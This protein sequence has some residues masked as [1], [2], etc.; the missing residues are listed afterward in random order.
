MTWHR[1]EFPAVD[2]RGKNFDTAYALDLGSM[3][4]GQVWMNGYHLGR[5][6]N[7]TGKLPDN[8]GS[9][10]PHPPATPSHPTTGTDVAFSID[11]EAGHGLRHGCDYAG[12]FF[13]DKC[14]NG[15]QPGEMTQRYYHVP[16]EWLRF[17]ESGGSNVVVLFEELGGLV[18]DVK[19]VRVQREASL[20]HSPLLVQR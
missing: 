1:I 17:G 10:Y 6:Y 19:L 12:P 3:G 14:R 5:Y 2:P 9:P 8:P 7:V 4:K 16:R 15:T 20:G 11:T 13:A 18:N